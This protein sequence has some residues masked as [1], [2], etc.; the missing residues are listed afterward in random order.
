MAVWSSDIY[1][2]IKHKKVH[3]MLRYVYYLAQKLRNL[4]IYYSRSSYN[5]IYSFTMIFK[6]NWTKYWSIFFVHFVAKT[7]NFIQSILLTIIYCV[8]GGF[9]TDKQLQE[10][11]GCCFPMQAMLPV[12]FPFSQFNSTYYRWCLVHVWRRKMSPCTS[13]LCNYIFSGTQRSWIACC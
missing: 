2:S 4:F 12:G 13:S 10:N 11:R 5:G 3:N 7:V 1:I 8:Y 9:T 6:V